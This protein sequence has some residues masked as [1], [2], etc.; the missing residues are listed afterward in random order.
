[1]KPTAERRT[2]LLFGLLLLGL[3]GL[4]LWLDRPVDSVLPPARQ[5]TNTRLDPD[6]QVVRVKLD[7]LT[8]L[9]TDIG[10][11]NPDG[12]TWKADGSRLS[13][14]AKD[15][16]QFNQL[17]MDGGELS[18]Y[19]ALADS[20]LR[21]HP[22]ADGFDLPVSSAKGIRLVT[23]PADLIHSLQLYQKNQRP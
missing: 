22:K 21:V 1:M 7:S 11:D 20:P 6:R 10:R 8:Q 2:L 3:T 18:T 14:R 13:I 23:L 15:I 12:F 9:L 19:A 4:I 16:R 17:F 5:L